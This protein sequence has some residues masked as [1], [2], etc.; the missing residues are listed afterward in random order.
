MFASCSRLVLSAVLAFTACL[1]A[2]AGPANGDALNRISRINITRAVIET[3]GL[4]VSPADIA[5]MIADAERLADS[6][7]MSSASLSGRFQTI[8][9][10]IATDPLACSDGNENYRLA[11]ATIRTYTGD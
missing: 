11:L 7:D 10:R 1:P 5:H 6:L 9:E 2:L 3:C 4:T 8:R